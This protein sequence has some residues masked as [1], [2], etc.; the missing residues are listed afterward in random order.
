[1]KYDTAGF[2]RSSNIHFHINYIHIHL[3][4]LHISIYVFIV[5]CLW[6]VCMCLFV[7]VYVMLYVFVTIYVSTCTYTHFHLC[8][9]RFIFHIPCTRP[10]HTTHSS[11]Y[12]LYIST[13]TYISHFISHIHIHTF[14]THFHLYVDISYSIFHTNSQLYSRRRAGSAQGC[15]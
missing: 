8:S 9:T 12:A 7:C 14:H 1:M 15:Q 11:T 3:S 5:W 4:I 2:T 6:Y 10:P 13:Y